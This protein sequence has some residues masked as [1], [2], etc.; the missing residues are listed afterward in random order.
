MT[1]AR[2]RL[3]LATVLGRDGAFIA[4][5]GGV[6]EVVPQDLREVF[7]R[8]V[9]SPGDVIE[10]DERRGAPL[11]GVHG[12]GRGATASRKALRRTKRREA[13]APPPQV[14]DFRRLGPAAR[15]ERVSVT[16]ESGS[17]N[18][19]NSKMPELKLGPMRCRR[20]S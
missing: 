9:S 19:T 2:D 14:V 15:V 13:E 7:T 17:S 11:P 16:S 20:P 5:R 18:V 1:R 6:G 8:A 3:S 4:A 12:R 10:W